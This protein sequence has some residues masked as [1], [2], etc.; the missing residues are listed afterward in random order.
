VGALN[1][2]GFAEKACSGVV[3]EYVLNVDHGVT[4]LGDRHAHY[5][6]SA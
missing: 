2:G 3:E 6:S 1:R 4:R 5:S